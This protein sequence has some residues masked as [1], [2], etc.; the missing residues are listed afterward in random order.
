[1]STGRFYLPGTAAGNILPLHVASSRRVNEEQ[2]LRWSKCNIKV[3]LSFRYAG[4]ALIPVGPIGCGL[5]SIDSGTA[6]VG[7]QTAV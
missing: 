2:K 6:P 1:M 3:S 4:H 5:T 7:D